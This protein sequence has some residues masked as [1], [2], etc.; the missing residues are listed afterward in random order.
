MANGASLPCDGTIVTGTSRFDESSLID[1][2][3]PVEKS[4]GDEVF[5][6]AIDQ[7]DPVTIKI[8]RLSGDSMLDQVISAVREG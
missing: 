6:G 3:L 8:T 7:A 4:V 2:P 1:E 5:S